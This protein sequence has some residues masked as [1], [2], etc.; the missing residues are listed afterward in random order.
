MN[1][2][3]LIRLPFNVRLERLL[4]RV[5]L[6]RRYARRIASLPFIPAVGTVRYGRDRVIEFNGRNSQYH[7][8]YDAPYHAGYELETCV[9]LHKLL[10][11]AGTLIDA[12]SNWGYFA[13]FASALPT[14]RGSCVCY[15]PSAATFADLRQCI[16][17][18]GLEQRIV[19]KQMGLGAAVVRLYLDE[20]HE[21]SGLTK[22]SERGSGDQVQ[23]TTLD[24][25][26][27]TEVVLIKID[28]EGMELAVLQGAA[29]TIHAQRPWLIVEN[30]LHHDSPEKT[31]GSIRWMQQ[32]GYVVLMPAA[33][34]QHGGTFVPHHYGSPP[35]T[36]DV[37]VDWTRMQFLRVTEANR[38]LLPNQLN[39][40]GCPQ[41]KLPALSGEVIA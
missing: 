16:A 7:A 15:E 20:S 18:A 28:V 32:Q 38:F 29:Q 33:C 36:N 23:V 25:E 8:L 1:P 11:G 37:D 6:L 34:V 41:E 5:P 2:F 10:R 30:F 9:L 13:L 39:L 21:L 14:F 26:S 12:G 31:L 3:S 17:Q 4:R 24:E 22:L 40:F 19:A 27:P 35:P